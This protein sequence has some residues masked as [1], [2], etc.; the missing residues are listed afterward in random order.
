VFLFT[1]SLLA[2]IHDHFSECYYDQ[3][4]PIPLTSVTKDRVSALL[5]SM[6]LGRYKNDFFKNDVDGASLNSAQSPEDLIQMG[7]MSIH[8]HKLFDRINT[9]WR[10]FGVK[11]NDLQKTKAT[12]K[13]S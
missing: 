9:Q 3:Q 4:W 5:D 8:A 11:E 6:N 1:C 7:L 13:V 2:L 12:F 10:K